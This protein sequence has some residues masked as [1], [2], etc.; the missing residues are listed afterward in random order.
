MRCESRA[1]TF[2][3][4]IGF[5][6]H[7]R[8]LNLLHKLRA[9]R[10]VPPHLTRPP[11]FPVSQTLRYMTSCCTPR[12]TWATPARGCGCSRRARYSS[13]VVS[14]SWLGSHSTQPSGPTPV[15]SGPTSASPTTPAARRRG[16]PT[17]MVIHLYKTVQ[18]QFQNLIMTWMEL[19][20][21]IGNDS[22][23][24]AGCF[25]L[26]QPLVWILWL[27]HLDVLQAAVTNML[28]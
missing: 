1:K 10:D 11:C 24:S 20:C 21:V 26:F 5:L 14:S 7:L 16:R 19:P 2:P 9:A 13:R 3:V 28:W 17:T 6:T 15:W 4:H 8:S 23:T 25:S 12:V 27:I 18:S 22:I